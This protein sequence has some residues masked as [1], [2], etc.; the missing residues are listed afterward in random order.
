M[1]LWLNPFFA[2]EERRLHPPIFLTEGWG[3]CLGVRPPVR[4]NL[5]GGYIHEK[6]SDM[7]MFASAI[8]LSTELGHRLGLSE[9]SSAISRIISVATSSGSLFFPTR[10]MS[11]AM[12]LTRSLWMVGIKRFYHHPALTQG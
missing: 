12:L 1:L 6:C 4:A 5:N 10:L 9:M 3:K 8:R 7:N 2:K 11:A